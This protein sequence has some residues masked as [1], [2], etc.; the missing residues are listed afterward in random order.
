MDYYEKAL[1]NQILSSRRDVDSV[2]STEV[3]YHQNMWPGRS[4]KIGTVIEYSRYGG[5]GSCCNGTGLESYTK[6]QETIYFRSADESTLYVN[7]FIASTLTWPDR[8]F[9]ITQ[10]TAYPTQGTSRLRFDKGQG[11]LKVR[12]RVPSWARTGYTVSVNGTRQALAAAPDTYVTLDRQWT[13][14]DTIDISMPFSFRVEKA[15]NDKAIQSVLYGPTLMVVRDGTPS[16][17]EF[18]F[19]KDL[20]LDGDLAAAIEP[21]DVPMHFTTHGY[22]LAPYYI[23]YLAPGS[24]TP[25]TRM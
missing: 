3:T 18:T 8:G 9:V 6:Y 10:E 7:L 20:K 11:R 24:S 14:G 23:S 2:T 12:L 1:H 22:T 15:L 19:F 16:Y 25:T 17:R 21:T 5:N 4:R 13:K